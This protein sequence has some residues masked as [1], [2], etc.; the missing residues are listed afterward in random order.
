MSLHE[1]TEPASSP[2]PYV[3][4]VGASAGGLEALEL[5]FRAVPLDSGMVFVVIQH[6]SP[7][8]KSMMDELLGRVTALP[9]IRPIGL[10]S[11]WLSGGAKR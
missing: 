1:N 2:P 5:F 10:N 6:L 7:D 11:I 4:G 8:F 9:I 3:V